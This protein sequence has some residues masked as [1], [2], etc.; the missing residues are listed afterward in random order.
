MSPNR[1]VIDVPVTLSSFPVMNRNPYFVLMAQTA[2]NPVSHKYD[3]TKGS[4]IFIV[5]FHKFG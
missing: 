4:K 5:L 2:G 3:I 1:G